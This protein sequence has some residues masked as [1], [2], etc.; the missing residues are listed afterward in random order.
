MVYNWL[1]FLIRK[2]SLKLAV[3]SVFSS[4]CLQGRAH[5][6]QHSGV[7][8]QHQF[9]RQVLGLC[10]CNEMQVEY[11]CW[12]L[13]GKQSI[14]LLLAQNISDSTFWSVVEGIGNSPYPS[15]GW[16]I[17]ADEYFLFISWLILQNGCKRLKSLL[18]YSS[19]R[20]IPLVP[21]L[22]K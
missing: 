22:S 2:D 19:V 21:P 18:W 5:A 8:R 7:H 14:F 1:H 4:W 6:L 20:N 10:A 3:Y 11:G 16:Q 12:S 17:Q 9:W 15:N 13:Q